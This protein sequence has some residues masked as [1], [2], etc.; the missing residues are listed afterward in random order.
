[1]KNVNIILKI[2][3]F[4]NA[5]MLKIYILCVFIST[6]WGHL[7]GPP[8]VSLVVFFFFFTNIIFILFINLK[9]PKGFLL[10]TEIKVFKGMI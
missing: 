2:Y 9:E 1:M 10:V 4:L 3:I 8:E 7:T 5:I 6:L